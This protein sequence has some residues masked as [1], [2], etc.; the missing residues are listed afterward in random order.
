MCARLSAALRTSTCSSGFPTARLSENVAVADASASGLFFS[1]ECARVLEGVVLAT[2]ALKGARLFEAAFTACPTGPGA[3]LA[4]AVPLAVDSLSVQRVLFT[5]PPV[6]LGA[7]LAGAV[8]ESLGVCNGGF[9]WTFALVEV[10]VGALPS[11]AF[12]V[13]F[14]ELE[15][16]PF[17]VLAEYDGISPERLVPALFAKKFVAFPD[18]LLSVTMSGGLPS[19]FWCVR[20]LGDFRPECPIE[21]WSTGL[22]ASVS[23][24]VSA[25]PLSS[26]CVGPTALFSCDESPS[27][28]TPSGCSRFETSGPIIRA[29]PLL[30]E[31]CFPLDPAAPDVDDTLPTLLPAF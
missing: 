13:F 20:A 7:L 28:V 22:Y 5:D 1:A 23:V 9:P 15:R 25:W 10:G 4:A 26:D 19:L 6:T 18:S 17:P 16:E 3:G 8:P 31:T 21:A 30:T 24:L 14:V 29:S 2:L 12:S 11:S 27:A